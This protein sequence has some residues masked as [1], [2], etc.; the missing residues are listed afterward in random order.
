MLIPPLFFVIMC[1]VAYKYKLF[2]YFLNDGEFLGIVYYFVSFLILASISYV[3]NP[4]IYAYGIGIMCMGLADG[5]APLVAG[6]LKSRNILK[7]KTFTG[8][9]TVLVVSMFVVSTFNG[10]FNLDLNVFKIIIIAITAT[11]LE[12]FG[13][14]GLDNLYLPLGVAGITY[15]MGVI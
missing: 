3:H 6:F 10:Y 13:K 2:N 11:L 9:F 7:N 8:T 5:F 4:F 1:L 15:L 14:K 12:L